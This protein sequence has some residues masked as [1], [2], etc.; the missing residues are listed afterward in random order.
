MSTAIF[1][2][3]KAALKAKKKITLVVTL[4]AYGAKQGTSGSVKVSR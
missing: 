4:R 3:A 2:K 1:K